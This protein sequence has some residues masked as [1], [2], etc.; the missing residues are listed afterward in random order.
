MEEIVKRFEN[1]I[2]NDSCVIIE[3]NNSVKE[4]DKIIDQIENH[5]DENATNETESFKFACE[6]CD[7]K[8]KGKRSLTKHVKAIHM[9]HHKCDKC[10]YN[11]IDDSNLKV[12]VETNHKDVEI[13]TSKKR[14]K[15]NDDLP[16]R[17]KLK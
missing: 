13:E 8:T 12:H 1:I 5:H 15:N 7:H 10:E 4:N 11:A 16:S 2:D 3:E 14:E 6:E 9:V 17:K